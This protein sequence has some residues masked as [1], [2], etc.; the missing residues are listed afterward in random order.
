MSQIKAPAFLE[1][2][3]TTGFSAKDPDG[4]ALQ[5]TMV[6]IGRLNVKNGKIYACDPLA[7]YLEE[8][9]TTDFPKGEFPVQVALAHINDDERIGF[10]RIKFAD[11]KPVRWEYA[12][13]DGQ[14]VNEL[15]KGEIFGYSVESGT[16]SFMDTSGYADYDNLYKEDAELSTVSKQLNETYEDTRAWLMWEGKNSNVAIFSTGYGDGL[17]ATYIGYD[18]GGNICRLVSDFNMLEWK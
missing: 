4:D 9:F 10:A 18:T 2:A 12:V 3:F 7:L 17:Y 8:P 15:E 6:D 11:T 16:G 14:D 13:T 1:D 5:F